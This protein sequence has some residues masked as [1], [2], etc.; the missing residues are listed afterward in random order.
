MHI[1]IHTRIYHTPGVLEYRGTCYCNA[2]KYKHQRMVNTR[3]YT[4]YAPVCKQ[5]PQSTV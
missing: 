4:C 3:E 1:R 5:R 2:R